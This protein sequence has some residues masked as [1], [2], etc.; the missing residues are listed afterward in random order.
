MTSLGFA[1][2]STSSP[3]PQLYHCPPL[4]DSMKIS[5][6]ASRRMN[7]SLPLG[8]VTSRVMSRMLRLCDSPIQPGFMLPWE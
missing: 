6:S 2:Q 5:V 8:L 4:E 3:S 1:S 7:A